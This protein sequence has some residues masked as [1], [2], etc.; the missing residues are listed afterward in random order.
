MLTR[1]LCTLR[2]LPMFA[3]ASP[4]CCEA[5]AEAAH[6]HEV[7]K[8]STL[9]LQG[10]RAHTVQFVVDGWVK[11]YRVAPFGGEAIIRL[12]SRGRSLEEMAALKGVTHG[13][14]A[15]AVTDS[16][17]LSI[18]AATFR[19]IAAT[20]A[21][22]SAALLQAVIDHADALTDDLEQMKV[23]N[24]VQRVALFLLAL[25]G[26]QRG[27]A[28]L[29]LPYEKHLIAGSL[30]MKPESLSRALARLKAQGVKV[31]DAE[32]QIA[33]LNAL[34]DF[35]QADPALSWA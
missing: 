3:A 32:V 33:D 11:L 19:R 4:Q 20:Q 17:I 28:H 18:D 34:R 12:Q 30:G 22:L 25:A 14:S 35:A 21:C 6:V 31:Q 27:S 13:L 10:E 15:E 26:T 1:T 9:F 7:D 29:R 24:G 2:N 8:G 5:L 23:R 16:T